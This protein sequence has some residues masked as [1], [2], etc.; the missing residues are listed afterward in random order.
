MPKETY[1][2]IQFGLGLGDIK[3]GSSMDFVESKLG[4]PEF[5]ERTDFLSD[6]TDITEYWYYYNKTLKASFDKDDDY[7]LGLF[8]I[9]D[10]KYTLYGECLIG[11]SK[12][13][14]LKFGDKHELGMWESS[15]VTTPHSS[16]CEQIA[17]DNF[18]LDFWFDA[19]LVESISW[20]HYWKDDEPLWPE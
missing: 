4:K 19:N 3:F 2:E 8:Q 5:K 6:G 7:R 12:S 10:E 15:D 20:G 16:I 9:Y 14:I 11:L 13:E 17:F 18:S 1:N